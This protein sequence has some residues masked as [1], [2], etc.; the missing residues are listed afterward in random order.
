MTA[1][2]YFHCLVTD[3]VCSAIYIPV[4]LSMWS[5]SGWLRWDLCSFCY[6]LGQ[7]CVGAQK[8]T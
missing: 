1:L 3:K 2:R 4:A 8:E 6:E 5:H 7:V